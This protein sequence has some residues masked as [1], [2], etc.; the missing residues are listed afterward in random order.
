MTSL[1]GFDEGVDVLGEVELAVTTGVKG[2]S[3]MDAQVLH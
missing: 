3:L 2:F 1:E